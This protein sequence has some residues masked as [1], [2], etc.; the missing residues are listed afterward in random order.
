M[1]GKYSCYEY[2]VWRNDDTGCYIYVIYD[3]D[4]ESPIRTIIRQANEWYDTELDAFKAAIEQI[5]LL[6]SGGK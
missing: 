2:I 3:N 5:D 1:I 4:L 6:E